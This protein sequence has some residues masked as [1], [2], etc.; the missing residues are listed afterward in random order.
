MNS[1]LPGAK[2]YKWGD[3]LKVLRNRFFAAFFFSIIKE[4]NTIIKM[5]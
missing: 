1:I 5:L 4:Y 3:A 2:E